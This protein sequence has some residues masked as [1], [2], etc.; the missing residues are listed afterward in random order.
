MGRKWLSLFVCQAFVCFPV[1]QIYLGGRLSEVCRWKL[2]T[3]RACYTVIDSYSVMWLLRSRLQPN[4]ILKSFIYQPW[5]SRLVRTIA[6]VLDESQ[7]MVLFIF[8][9]IPVK[10]HPAVIYSSC[11]V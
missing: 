1:G 10:F 11:C 5:C 8:L 9:D 7:H 3:S 2:A 6:I 4:E